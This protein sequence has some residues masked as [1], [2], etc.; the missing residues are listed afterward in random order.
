MNPTEVVK[1]FFA[2]I[3]R[4]AWREAAELIDPSQAAR[5]QQEQLG[6]TV[7]WL[8]FQHVLKSPGPHPSGFGSSGAASAQELARHADDA[9]PGYRD[10]RTL[11]D[12]VALSPLEFLARRL[13]SSRFFPRYQQGPD[14][15]PVRVPLRVLGQVNY[16]DDVVYIVYV[17]NHVTSEESDNVLADVPHP[18]ALPVFRRGDRWLI[19]LNVEL[20]MAGPELHLSDRDGGDEP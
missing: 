18:D 1:T 15:K 20:M 5:F 9:V 12:L 7:A 10:V 6:H 2:A 11:Q 14:G 19:G 4:G 8:D 3:R 13:E 17:H 16:S